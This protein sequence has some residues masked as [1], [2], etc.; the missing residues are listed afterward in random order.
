MLI[1]YVLNQNDFERLLNIPRKLRDKLILRLFYATGMRTMELS[2]LKRANVDIENR[3]L[4]IL[5]SKKHIELPIPIDSKTGELLK[6]Y[7]SC[8][9]GNKSEYLFPS[10][11]LC[12]YMT[13][14][15]LIH[16]VKS[17]ARKLGLPH[18]DKWSPR[19]FRRRI[20][21]YWVQQKG[22]LTALQQLLR[23]ELFSSTAV[24]I[25]GIRFDDELRTEYDRIIH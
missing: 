4:T 20:A 6:E 24:Y 9:R 16:I 19:W 11:R 8:F 3:T 21:R 17:N 23:H 12:G 14:E 22:D 13:K 18:S 25:N 2:K 7:I 10:R 5:D 15:G 1:H